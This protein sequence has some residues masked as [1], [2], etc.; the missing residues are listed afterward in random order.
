[1]QNMAKER[2]T[3]FQW[4][5]QLEI[6]K[7][8]AAAFILYIPFHIIEEWA[9]GFASWAYTYWRIPSYTTTK[10]LIHNGY[11]AFFLLIGLLLYLLKPNTFLPFGVGIVIWGFM[12]TLNHIVCSFVFLEYE[13]GILTS[14]LWIP[15]AF[16][17]Y[18][19]MSKKVNKNKLL[20]YSII[21]AIAYW[22]IPMTLFIEIDKLLKL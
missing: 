12:N 10:W 7:L 9:F 3:L 22:S 8:I 15:L 18:N 1:M 13:P 17:V 19:R 20:L 11:F 14:L 16:Q 4:L 6:R 2:R 5:N 21:V